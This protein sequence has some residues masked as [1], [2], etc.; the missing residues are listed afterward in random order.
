MVLQVICLSHFPHHPG[1][2]FGTQILKEERFI[3]FQFVEISVHSDL[4]ERQDSLAQEHGEEMLIAW[5]TGSKWGEAGREIQ[6]SGSH[7]Q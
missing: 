6:P 5:W 7:P 1:K 4:A 3:L 2:V